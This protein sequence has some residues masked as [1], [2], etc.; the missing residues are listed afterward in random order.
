MNIGNELTRVKINRVHTGKKGIE[1]EG[2]NLDV[3]KHVSLGK[4]AYNCIK[5]ILRRTEL[6]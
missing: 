3:P 6:L 1:S 5:E 4:F 2:D